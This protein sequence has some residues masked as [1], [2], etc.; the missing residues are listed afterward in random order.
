MLVP[1]RESDAYAQ[2]LHWLH[3]AEG[4]LMPHVVSV[5]LLNLVGARTHPMWNAMLEG[6]AR[7]LAYAD[8]LGRQ[9]Y[10]AADQFTAC[11]IVMGSALQAPSQFKAELP[12]FPHV[13]ESAATCT[14]AGISEG[15]AL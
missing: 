3:F 1:D 11:D 2:Y 10:L 7:D 8:V 5:Y 15:P 4:T 6:L 13:A 9:P 14:A 12:A